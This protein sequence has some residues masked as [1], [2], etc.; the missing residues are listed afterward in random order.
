MRLKIEKYIK[1]W[2][3]KCYYNGIPDEAPNEIKDMV[4]SYKRIVFAILKND[5]S[6]KYLGFSPTKSAVYSDFKRIEI[7]ARTTTKVIQ[8]KLFQ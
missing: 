6:L 5:Y 4:P 2:E 7:E 1:E 3:S 8:L